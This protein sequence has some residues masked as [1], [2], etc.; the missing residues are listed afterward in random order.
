VKGSKAVEWLAQGLTIC[1]FVI[2]CWVVHRA[3]QVRWG[4]V[5]S[6]F[7]AYV[8]MG[9]H[10][11][12]N[13]HFE[14]RLNL[15]DLKS[16]LTYAQLREARALESLKPLAALFQDGSPRVTVEIAADDP[17]AFELGRDRL[18]LGRDWIERDPTQARRALIM[19]ALKAETPE[20]YSNQFQLEVVTD[21]LMLALFDDA[22]AWREPIGHGRVYSLLHD[23]RFP[24]A[25]PSFAQYCRSP[26]RSLAHRKLCDLPTPDSDDLQDRVWGFRPLLASALYRLFDKLPLAQKLA[27]LQ[28]VRAGMK[29][30]LTESLH[31]DDVENLVDWFEKTLG[32]YASALD[33]GQTPEAKFALKRVLKELQVES[34]TH[35]E[36][37]VDLTHTPAWREIL[38]QLKTRARFHER[39]RALVF[40]PEGETALPSGLPVDWAAS[41]VRSQKH[42]LIACEWPRP[43]DAVHVH[44]RRIYARQ[45]C[46]KLDQPFWD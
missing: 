1:T 26:F 3:L 5:N 32:E 44:A 7:I 33:M 8:R 34:P 17:S 23:A 21:F 25:A 16:G 45:S 19:A 46:G 22:G 24:T 41:D 30:P 36:L 6:S 12:D 39:E 20:T 15:S 29:L 43:A 28:R 11:L 37:T 9:D 18:R 38:E 35:W 42:V 40:T 2:L 31:R 13:C 14:S 27:T 4:C 10:R